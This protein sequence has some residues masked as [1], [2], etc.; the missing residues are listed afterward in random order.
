MSNLRSAPLP[1]KTARRHQPRLAARDLG[2]VVAVQEAS[3]TTSLVRIA[4]GRATCD[5]A[6]FTASKLACAHIAAAARLLRGTA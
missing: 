1:L 2:H 3:G 5:C 4:D 6:H